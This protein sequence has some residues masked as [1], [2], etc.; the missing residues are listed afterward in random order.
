MRELGVDH[1]ASV[2]LQLGDSGGAGKLPQV[3][4]SESCARPVPLCV[5]VG[6]HPPILLRDQEERVTGVPPVGAVGQN[7]VLEGLEAQSKMQV[8]QDATAA[9]KK[10][11][12]Q[13]R[14]EIQFESGYGNAN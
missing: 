14:I 8:R 6:M 4:W 1:W 11:Y 9:K 13:M 10:R 3:V 5:V 12:T 2:C 7:V